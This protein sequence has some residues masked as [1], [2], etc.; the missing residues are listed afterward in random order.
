MAQQE[1][2]IRILII[3][4]PNLN[5][6]GLRDAE[7]YGTLT[8]DKVNR[9]IRKHA[10]SQDVEIKIFQSNHEGKLIDFIHSR[11]KW[12]DGIV[13]NPGALTHY[14]YAIRDA[15]EAVKLPTVEVH[16]S[17]IHNREDF[18]KISVIA[19]ICVGQIY[20]DDADSY[21]EGMDLL[22]ETLDNSCFSNFC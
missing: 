13:I 11:R 14:S 17:D 7:H 6:L 3:H 4:G 9:K 18:R 12:A 2:P 20:G 22:L 16:F 5:L 15:I 10:Q 8:L 21:L 1:K 19:P